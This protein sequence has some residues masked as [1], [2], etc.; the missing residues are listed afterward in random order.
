MARCSS[1]TKAGKRCTKY[2]RD[3]QEHCSTHD[4]VKPGR[5]TSRIEQDGILEQLRLGFLKTGTL[6][7]A[8]QE[9]GI[10]KSTL[11]DWIRQG[12][13]DKANGRDTKHRKVLEILDDSKDELVAELS[14]QVQAIAIRDQDT[15]TLLRLLAIL[16]PETFR[17]QKEV[18]H[19]GSD[20]APPISVTGPPPVQVLHVT[21]DAGLEA[22]A[23]AVAAK[24]D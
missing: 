23:E 10:G 2:A 24:D 20:T 9:A 8:R 16:D 14:A 1:L 15:K 22:E 3:G 19:G 12:R 21:L 5:T 11:A 17:E 13:E 18:R 6:Q 7:G 4:Q